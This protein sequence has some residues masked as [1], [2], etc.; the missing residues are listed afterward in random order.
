MSDARLRELERR[1]RVSGAAADEMALLIE[2]ARAGSIAAQERVELAAFCG[3]D[4]ARSALGRVPESPAGFSPAGL[5]AFRLA[6]AEASRAAE[7][8]R[9]LH[10]LSA[11]VTVESVALTM[12]ANLDVP[13]D[14]IRRGIEV[15]LRASDAPVSPLPALLDGMDERDALDATRPVGPEHVVLAFL[16]RGGE[17][18]DVLEELGLRYWDT[19][20]EIRDI[21]AADQG[22]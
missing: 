4:A 17:A 12:F 15:R 16:L 10:L 21:I 7:P 11:L 19:R 1:H 20:E 3:I 2:R 8:L 22:T 18:A 13:I 14:R 5:E 6:R 9:E